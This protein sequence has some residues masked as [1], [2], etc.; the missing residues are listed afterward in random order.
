VLCVHQ[1]CL[2]MAPENRQQL[3]NPPIHLKRKSALTIKNPRIFV[4]TAKRNFQFRVETSV[5]FVPQNSVI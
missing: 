1:E 3:H 4:Y 5:P 2:T